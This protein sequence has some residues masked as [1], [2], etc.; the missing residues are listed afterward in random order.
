MLRVVVEH[1]AGSVILRCHGRIVAGTE[2]RVL[3]DAVMCQAHQQIVVLDLSGVDMIDAAG[4]GVLVFVQTLGCVVG[5][6]L[7]LMNPTVPVREL[8]E[9]T[10][11]N[12]VFEISSEDVGMPSRHS[13]ATN[14]D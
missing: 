8:L 5:F 10:R 3:R 13:V 14:A 6:D 11:L 12:S 1:S 7:K 9:I 4:L 2:A